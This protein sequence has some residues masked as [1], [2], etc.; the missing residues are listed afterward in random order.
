[1]AEILYNPETGGDEIKT[2]HDPEAGLSKLEVPNNTENKSAFVKIILYFTFVIAIM[3][4]I[5]GII[6]TALDLGTAG[7]GGWILRIIFGIVKVFYLGLFWYLSG[8][9]DYSGGRITGAQAIKKITQYS[10]VFIWA[11]RS[12][13]ITSV[14]TGI[15]P[16]LGDVIDVLPIETFNIIFLFFIFPNIVKRMEDSK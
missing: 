14:I 8:A 6:A 16:I 13:E 12:L 7:I 1:M 2:I 3:V 9:F 15:I 5:M 4:D 10:K 11:T